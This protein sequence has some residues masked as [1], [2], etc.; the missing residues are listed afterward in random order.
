MMNENQPRLEVRLREIDEAL[1]A[2]CQRVT[3]LE[4]TGP[5]HADAEVHPPHASADDVVPVR[6]ATLP[7]SPSTWSGPA[8]LSLIGRTFVILGGA[9]LLR[10]FTESGSVPQSSGIVLG[11][12]YASVWIGAA[13]RAAVQRPASGLFHGLAGLII[14]VALLWEASTRFGFLSAGW[15]GTVLGLLTLVALSVAW[16]RRLQ[17]LALIV[18]V[19]N[20]AATMALI[21]A[22]GRVLPFAASAVA[23][24]VITCWIGADRRWIWPQWT[25]AMTADL[26]MLAVVL[27]AT[28]PSPAEPPLGAFIASMVFAGL[29]LEAIVV[30]GVTGRRPSG[31]FE[32]VQTMAVFAIGAGGALGAAGAV[33]PALQIATA[34]GLLAAGTLGYAVA[35]VRAGTFPPR[36]VAYLTTVAGALAMLGGWVG[37]SGLV[38]DGWLVLVAGTLI[39]LGARTDR[40][41]IALHAALFATAGGVSTGLLRFSVEAWTGTPSAVIQPLAIVALGTCALGLAR[42]S[43]GDN[44]DAGWLRG[45]SRSIL[46]VLLVAGGGACVVD[47]LIR[48]VAGANPSAAVLASIRTITLATGAIGLAAAARRTFG[49]E[50]GQLAY[51]VVVIVGGKILVED[52]HVSP[53]SMLFVILGVYGISL[54]LTARL[55]GARRR[56]A[57][58]GSL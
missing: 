34:S 54:I 52:L 57:S 26:L 32:V 12:A 27:R 14:G 40:A 7:S 39:W 2:L 53:P 9:Y 55:F 44:D 29:Y 1:S 46:A 13:D 30:P 15:S 21:A 6:A 8:V 41:I 43:H 35:L 28:A 11:F 37:L 49:R 19:S 58:R 16:H 45:L 25:T 5:S 36:M 17:G 42:G 4:R 48:L 23:I 20:V 22:T 18:L 10:A 51:P 33:S 56:P 50:L 24:G 31:T 47:L 38:R 3:A